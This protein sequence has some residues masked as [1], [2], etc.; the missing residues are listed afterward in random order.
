M[1]RMSWRRGVVFSL[2]LVSVGCA[3][4]KEDEPVD[5]SGSEEALRLADVAEEYRERHLTDAPAVHPTT[6]GVDAWDLYIVNMAPRDDQPGFA[7]V[8]AVG[9]SAGE[10]RYA[11][12]IDA[13]SEAMVLVDE[14]TNEHL[15]Q[16]V[17]S[18]HEELADELRE[19]QAKLA[20]SRSTNK[21]SIRALDANSAKR[22]KQ[23]RCIADAGLLLLAGVAVPAVIGAMTL[24][25]FE[26]SAVVAVT[27]GVASMSAA[28]GGG[29]AAFELK[30]QW[31]ER[32]EV[33][34]AE[35]PA[36]VAK[37][38]REMFSTASADCREGFGDQKKRASGS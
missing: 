10:P 29:T 23:A 28:L 35:L 16:L 5:G 1:A 24:V 4:A 6:L 32:G 30:Q 9:K 12:S 37:R 17:A 34:F 15:S 3:P 8:L 38:V 25:A 26:A 21:T 36:A 2:L 13:L 7:G 20:A 14:S 19:L 33:A 22:E 31:M 27:A 18:H 11:L